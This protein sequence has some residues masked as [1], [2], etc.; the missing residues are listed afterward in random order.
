[1]Y[2]THSTGRRRL[3]VTD[4]IKERR[5]RLIEEFCIMLPYYAPKINVL[6][7]NTLKSPLLGRA[8]ESFWKIWLFYVKWWKHYGTVLALQLYSKSPTICMLLTTFWATWFTVISLWVT[9]VCFCKVC[10]KCNTISVFRDICF[11]FSKQYFTEDTY[12]RLPHKSV[13][14]GVVQCFHHPLNCSSYLLRI[15]I[16]SLYNLQVH[17]MSH[18]NKICLHVL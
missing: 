4:F 13:W 18:L 2:T 9:V 16:T 10:S 12:F 17:H 11:K 15:W 14:V 7:L 5:S 1:M 3:K 6:D 8:S